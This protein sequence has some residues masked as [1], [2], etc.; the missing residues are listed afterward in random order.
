MSD[1]GMGQSEG[2][3]LVKAEFNHS[4]SRSPP[5]NSS[6]ARVR[7]NTPQEIST[8]GLGGEERRFQL[9]NF[10]YLDQQM[11]SG[12]TTE[13]AGNEATLQVRTCG[14]M[15]LSS[16][17]PSCISPQGEFGDYGELAT[18]NNFYRP[19]TLC[20]L[21]SLP[22]L[23]DVTDVTMS[24]LCGTSTALCH[25]LSPGLSPALA[26]PGHSHPSFQPRCDGNNMEWIALEL[27]TPRV[28][29]QK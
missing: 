22:A 15:A 9:F 14:F 7:T 21:P 1:P 26:V 25:L 24:P 28:L 8:G 11:P 16:R 5:W 6:R 12:Q 19:N 20:F 18:K 4:R 13:S 27:E 29:G 3:N 2:K 10:Q 23:S 17:I